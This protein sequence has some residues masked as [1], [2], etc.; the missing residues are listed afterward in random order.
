MDSS[1]YSPPPKMPMDVVEIQRILPHRYP[2]LMIDRVTE[3]ERMKRIVA[4]KNVTVN[5]PWFH[6]HF[7]GHPLMPGVLIIEAMAQA[8]GVLLL[9]DVPDRASK[10]V[11]FTGIDDAK[12]RRHVVPGDTVRFEVEVAQWRSRAGK[13]EGKAYVGDKLACEATL[14]CMLVP[15]RN[16]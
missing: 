2:F 16:D 13:M 5:E 15:K 10:I 1:P 14:S 9:M 4:I 11:V 3:V 6:G 7:P 12:F 8:G